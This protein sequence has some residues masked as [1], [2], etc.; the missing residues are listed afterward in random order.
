MIDYENV[1]GERLAGLGPVK[2]NSQVIVFYS[3]SVTAPEQRGDVKR[4]AGTASGNVT[5]EKVVTGT[6]NA[7]DFQLV[8]KLGLL[9][10][11]G[12]GAQPFHIVSNDTGFDCAVSYLKGQG[13]NVDRLGSSGKRAKAKQAIKAEPAPAAMPQQSVYL[14]ELLAKEDKP[15]DV[16]KILKAHKDK[17]AVNVAL[18][19]LY[20]NTDHAGRVYRKIKPLIGKRSGSSLAC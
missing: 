10:N 11:E 20:R 19:R 18:I 5:C 1:N 3:G 9:A 17:C 12:Q 2:K 6:K 14:A 7:L 13:F 4:F 15:E 8:A 16:R